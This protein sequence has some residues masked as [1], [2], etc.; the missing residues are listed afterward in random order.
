MPVIYILAINVSVLLHHLQVQKLVCLFHIS[1]FLANEILFWVAAVLEESVVCTVPFLISAVFIMAPGGVA[2][3]LVTQLQ[4]FYKN[5]KKDVTGCHTLSV[6]FSLSG[7]RILRII[8]DKLT[9]KLYEATIWSKVCGLPC[10]HLVG[11]LFP[12]KINQNI[13]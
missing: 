5:E 3:R 12:V 7:L 9:R 11:S 8:Q 4:C 1:S 10:S 2:R 13:E 6:S